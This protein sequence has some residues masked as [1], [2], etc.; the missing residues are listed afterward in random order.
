MNKLKI[1]AE[2][3]NICS[4]PFN[5]NNIIIYLFIICIH[6][7]VLILILFVIPAPF[8]NFASSLHL[9]SFNF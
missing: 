3:A 4:K 9:N 6:F 5:N 1:W 2:Y 7:S 8:L